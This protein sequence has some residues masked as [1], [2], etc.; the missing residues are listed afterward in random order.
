MYKRQLIFGTDLGEVKKT[1][2]FLSFKFSMK[3]MG[4]ADVILGVKII[5][6]NDGIRLTLSHYVEKVLGRFNYQDCLPVAT[7]FDSTYK[8]TR[9]SGRPITQL[10]Y[11]GHRMLDV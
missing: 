10:E 8:L 4:E 11:K 7:P 1:K 9:D 3:D 5:R 2:G 6:N